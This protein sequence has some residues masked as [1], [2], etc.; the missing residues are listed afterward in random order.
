MALANLV[1]SY[2]NSMQGRPYRREDC[3]C[4]V[5][6]TNIFLRGMIWQNIMPERH[7]QTFSSETVAAVVEKMIFVAQTSLDRSYGNCGSY[8]KLPWLSMFTLRNFWLIT[9][10]QL[11]RLLD[12]LQES[13]EKGLLTDEV[14]IQLARA[15]SVV[16][17][18]KE[19]PDG[20]IN[21]IDYEV[22]WLDTFDDVEP[23][24]GEGQ[25]SNL[26]TR[27]SVAP[28]DPPIHV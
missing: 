7:W 27:D 1:T 21:G 6:I 5:A 24:A 13:D 8:K 15:R 10:D 16:A 12:I 26:G 22:T 3:S 17:Y 14:K 23:L 9:P 28:S 2:D 4:L 19:T 25:H 11:G 20:Q 18:F